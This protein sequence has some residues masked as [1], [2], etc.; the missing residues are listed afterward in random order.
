MK[1]YLFVITHIWQ[2]YLFKKRHLA[3]LFSFSFENLL[4]LRLNKKYG[5]DLFL[6]GATSSVRLYV[7][8]PQVEAVA[9]EGSLLLDPTDMRWL[10]FGKV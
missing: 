4:V 1:K 2:T 3:E 10:Y 9:V 5:P 8:L 6:M 7:P